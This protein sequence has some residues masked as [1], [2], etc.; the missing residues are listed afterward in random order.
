M[1]DIA[2]KQHGSPSNRPAGGDVFTKML[3][4]MT[5]EELTDGLNE[6]LES[7]TEENY[8]PAL[9]DAY[10]AAL[11]RKAPMPEVPDSEAAFANFKTK[12]LQTFPAE[13]KT[14]SPSRKANSVWRIGLIAILTVICLMGGMVAAQASGVDVFGAIAR[15]TDGVFSLGTI[16]SDGA[17]DQ[18]GDS[19]LGSKIND[20]NDAE[21]YGTLQEALDAYDIT[22]FREPTWLPDG[23]AFENVEVDFWPDDNSF[24]SLFAK[25]YNGTNFLQIKIECYQGNANEQ[26]EKANASVETFAVDDFTV[27]L[28]ENINS[29]SAAWATEHYECY[30]S[31]NV[32]KQALKQM[33]LSAYAHIVRR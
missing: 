18:D 27:Y 15:W 33:V 32:E 28:L 12:L 22:E 4:A 7:M 31:G 10:L 29:T 9:I 26:L 11:D 25:Y 13:D 14:D 5:E 20:A 19:R 6:A 2:N 17:G 3:E 24:I 8:D 1:K 30:I 21:R 16:R 23:Y